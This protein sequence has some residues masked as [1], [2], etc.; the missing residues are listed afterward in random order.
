MKILPWLLG[1]R[2]RAFGWQ[3]KS[4]RTREFLYPIFFFYH[5]LRSD[6]EKSTDIDDLD[7]NGNKLTTCKWSSYIMSSRNSFT[8][9]IGL[10]HLHLACCSTSCDGLHFNLKSVLCAFTPCINL[11]CSSSGYRSH[12]KDVNEASV[13][14]QRTFNNTVIKFPS[15]FT[16]AI[17]CIPGSFL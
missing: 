3:I 13:T 5:N 16:L 11:H 6:W 4:Q 7:G 17:S 15:C 9:Q 8:L 1:D 2:A 10:K 14:L 12:V